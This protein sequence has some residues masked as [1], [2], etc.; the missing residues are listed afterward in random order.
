MVDA[1]YIRFLFARYL[2]ISPVRCFTPAMFL[3][4]LKEYFFTSA[5]QRVGHGFLKG[6]MLF[7]A[8]VEVIF[9]IWSRL[10]HLKLDL[11][12]VCLPIA[13]EQCRKTAL[14][15]IFQVA[16]YVYRGSI[17]SQKLQVLETMHVGRLSGWKT[18]VASA[19]Q[20]RA[21]QRTF[22]MEDIFRLHAESLLKSRESDLVEG[23]DAN[24]ND[25]RVSESDSTGTSGSVAGSGSTEPNPLRISIGGSP[26]DNEFLAFKRADFCSWFVNLDPEDIHSI[27]RGNLEEWIRRYSLFPRYPLPLDKDDIRQV[28]ELTDLLV[29]FL[30]IEPKRGY[31]PHVQSICCVDDPVQVTHR[32]LLLYAATRLFIDGFNFA[33]AR[34]YGYTQYKAGICSYFYRPPLVETPH[35]EPKLMPLVY[36]HGLGL[37]PSAFYMTGFMQ[38]IN[39]GLQ[40][41]RR[42][43]IVLSFPHLQQRPGWEFHCP[44]IDEM[45]ASMTMI[46]H[47]HKAVHAHFIAHSMGTVIAG[48]FAMRT[49]FVKCISLIDPVCILS[50]RAD[51]VKNNIYKPTTRASEDLL[52]FF[53]F[54]ESTTAACLLK[55]TFC[56]FNAFD[57]EQVKIPIFIAFGGDDPILPAFSM[58]RLVE[59]HKSQRAKDPD[60]PQIHLS[61]E[62]KYNHGH[63]LLH[64]KDILPKF[65]AVDE[66]AHQMSMKRRTR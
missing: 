65:R 29:Q 54:R 10:T 47:H 18:P 6:A 57:F 1:S 15:K 33:W 50:V 11:L 45:V 17:R 35:G 55:N 3:I 21:A 16:D 46:L 5:R 38:T 64:G 7:W 39:D 9:F 58:L 48:W 19:C 53:A 52:R 13:T 14:K 66:A 20:R 4:L 63:F 41:D 36:L 22:A 56:L 51:I 12:P 2:I 60:L 62:H 61:F 27:Q 59:Y 31:N 40:G 8:K 32:P 30:E 24:A 49:K 44:T 23:F 43:I 34:K 42:Q 28:S 37:G 25:D 26:A